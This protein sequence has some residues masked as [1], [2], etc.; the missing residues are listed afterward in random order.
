MEKKTLPLSDNNRAIR[1]EYNFNTGSQ[2]HIDSYEFIVCIFPEQRFRR[3]NRL[4]YIAEI[5][6][7]EHL[8]YLN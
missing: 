4:T 6:L 8:V 3:I 7:P 5:E 1:T 2:K